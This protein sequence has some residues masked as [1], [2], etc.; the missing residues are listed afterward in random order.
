MYVYDRI[1]YISKG[2]E[3]WRGKIEG[4][5][6]LAPVPRSPVKIDLYVNFHI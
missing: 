3:D 2:K 6:N 5:W 1:D 4:E